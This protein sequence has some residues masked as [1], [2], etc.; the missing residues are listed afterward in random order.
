MSAA[1]LPLA[2]A[3]AALGLGEIRAVDADGNERKP[4]A[5]TR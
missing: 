1:S 3:L 4:A 5:A 2:L